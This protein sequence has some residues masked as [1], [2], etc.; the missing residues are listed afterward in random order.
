MPLSEDG[1]DD[2]DTASVVRDLRADLPRLPIVAISAVPSNNDHLLSV[3]A[4]IACLKGELLQCL[5][6]V[7]V[8]CDEI[9]YETA[10]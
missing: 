9:R 6:D 3:G 1:Y 8:R 2:H 5:D 10:R 7:L 4:N